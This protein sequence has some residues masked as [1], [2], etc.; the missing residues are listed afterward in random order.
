MKKENTFRTDYEPQILISLNIDSLKNF[1][2]T[3]MRL[4]V[5]MYSYSKCLVYL[6]YSAKI[7]QKNRVHGCVFKYIYDLY[8]T[9]HTVGNTER[10]GG[11]MVSAPL[12]PGS[13]PGRGHCVVFLGKTLYSHGASL[14]PGV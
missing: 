12:A 11:L 9:I 4:S 7:Q 10:R 6:L 1:K 5:Q 14:H 3:T 2:N 13:S 8:H